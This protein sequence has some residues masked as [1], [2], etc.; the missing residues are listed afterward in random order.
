MN[1]CVLMAVYNGEK[2]LKEQI[3][4]VLI[5]S[6]VSLDIYISLDVSNDKSFE[7]VNEYVNK[8]NNIYLLPFGTRYGSA[9]QN[10]FRLL[11]DVDLEL[12]DYISF[13]DQDDVWLDYKLEKSIEQILITDSDAYSGNVTAFWESGE[14]VLLKKDDSQ[15]E[16]DYLFESSGPGCTFV[17]KKQLALKLKEALNNNGSIVD[18]LWL[19]DWFCYSFARFNNYKWTIG[20]EP[21]MLYR[22]HENNEVGASGGWVAMWSRAKV[23]L[24][25]NGLDKVIKQA[26]YLN[27]NHLPIQLIKTGSVL[28]LLKLAVLGRKCRRKSS[29]KVLFTIALLLLALK[30]VFK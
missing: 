15:V 24:S 7:I 4:S 22:Q 2:W 9:G 26:D 23:I 16:F 11:K 14:E 3:D 18:S 19:H 8:H 1:V 20:S 5:Q 17:L 21:L 28:G 25:G 13:S 29:E 27:Q 6:N 30:K 12:Y 10:F